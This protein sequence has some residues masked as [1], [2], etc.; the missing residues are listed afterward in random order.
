V[1]VIQWEYSD[2]W[3]PGG[4]T[5]AAAL[6][7]LSSAGYQSFLLKRNGLYRF[8]YGTWG[9]FFTYANFVSVLEGDALVTTEVKE[10]L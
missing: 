3:A 7:F 4:G 2:S 5:L 6:A 1:S 10:L 9:D 8:N